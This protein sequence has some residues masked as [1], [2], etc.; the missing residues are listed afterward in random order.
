MK[1]QSQRVSRDCA[2]QECQRPV[3]NRHI[4]PSLDGIVQRLSP[5]TLEPFEDV[6]CPAKH[7]PA[8]D[9]PALRDHAPPALLTRHVDRLR[10]RVG[11]AVD[12]VGIDDQRIVQLLRRA[13]ER[14][15]HEDPILIV[16]CGNEFLRDQVH[17]VVQ[18]AD[19]AELRE[20]IERDK[21]GG[22]QGGLVIRDN[23]WTAA[24]GVA[25]IDVGNRLAD[26]SLDR[27]IAL[28]L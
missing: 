3:S 5:E 18:G 21:T 2:G 15:Q 23:G 8:R 25:R 20:T 22:R 24:N 9:D 16:T 26:F 28:Q 6:G 12:V 19:D 17:A 1:P 11:K 4:L 7:V 27:D 13:R 14:A 10:E